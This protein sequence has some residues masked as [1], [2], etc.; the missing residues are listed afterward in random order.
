MRGEGVTPGPGQ[1]GMFMMCLARGL[2]ALLLLQKF[3][4]QGCSL[5]GSGAASE[6]VMPAERKKFGAFSIMWQGTFHRCCPDS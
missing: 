5:Y 1:R 6:P 4:L 3:R 2:L